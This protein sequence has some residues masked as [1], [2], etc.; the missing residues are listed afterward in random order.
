MER[1]GR[2]GLFFMAAMAVLASCRSAPRF[3]DVQAKEWMLVE[4]RVQPENITFDRQKLVDEGFGDIFTVQFD[5]DRLSGKG[6]PNRYRG[7]YEVGENQSLKIG[8]V[9]GTLMAPI[10]EP[11]R[12]K[13]REYFAWLANVYKWNLDGETLELYTKSDAGQEAVMIYTTGQKK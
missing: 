2:W 11:E 12:L 4:I 5:G 1:F 6:A 3:Q 8:N 7:P 13:E 10:R 9:A